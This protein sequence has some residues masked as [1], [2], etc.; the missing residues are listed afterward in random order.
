MTIEGRPD[1]IGSKEF[2]DK[3][4]QQARRDRLADM[5][6]DYLGDEDV[7]ARQFYEELINEAQSWVDYHQKNLDQAIEFRSLIAGHRDPL[8]L[9]EDRNSNFPGENTLTLGA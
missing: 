8:F 4:Y 9:T 1:I 6:G 5:I 2:N 7:T 3:I